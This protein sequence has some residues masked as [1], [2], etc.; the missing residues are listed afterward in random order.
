MDKSTPISEIMTKNVIVGKPTNTTAQLRELFMNYKLHHLVV[1]EEDGKTLVGIVSSNDLMRFSINNPGA[2]LAN[3]QLKDIM[4][5]NVVSVSPSTTLEQV[6]M[7]L[8]GSHFS[9]IPVVE[10]GSLVGIFTLR[11]LARVLHFMFHE[12]Y[13]F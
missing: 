9:A 5:S 3:T 13:N 6:V 1:T 2:D 11:D 7:M 10:N 12:N 4:T 8:Q